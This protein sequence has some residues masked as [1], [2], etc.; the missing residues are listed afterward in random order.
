VDGQLG[1][2]SLIISQLFSVSGTIHCLAMMVHGI[3]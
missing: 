2:Q 1:D 3:S